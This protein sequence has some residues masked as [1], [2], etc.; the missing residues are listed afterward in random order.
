MMQM[1]TGYVKIAVGQ[2]RANRDFFKNVVQVR[3][4]TID[5]KIK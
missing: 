1:V 4:N 3:V 2:L 5:I